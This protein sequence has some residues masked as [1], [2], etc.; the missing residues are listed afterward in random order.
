MPQ[1]AYYFTSYAQLLEQGAIALGEAVD[2]IVPT[3]NF[4]DILAG[5]YA[6]KGSARRHSN[7]REQ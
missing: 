5:W 3:G 6:K 4:G 2:F 7:L 1:I